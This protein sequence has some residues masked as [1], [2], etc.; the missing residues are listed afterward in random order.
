MV[1]NLLISHFLVADIDFALQVDAQ[2][3]PLPKARLEKESIY[4]QGWL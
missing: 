3:R 2:V 1:H 4:A